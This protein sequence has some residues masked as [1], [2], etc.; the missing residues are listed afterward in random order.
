MKERAAILGAGSLGTIMGAIVSDRHKDVDLVLIDANKPHVDMLNKDGATVT[1]YM[2]MKNIPVKAITPDQMEG[3]YDIVIVLTK[4]TA[5]KAALTQL[6]PY[7]NDNSVVCTLQNGIPEESVAA[8]V[9]RER[10]VGGAVGWGAGWLSPGVSQL[11]TKPEAMIIEIGNLDNTVNEKLQR[12]EQFI[13]LACEVKINLNLMGFRWAKLLMNASFSGMSA[14]LGCT[15]G[16][17]LDDDKAVACAVHVADELIKV[18]R[19]KGITIE[20]IVP[21]KDF[22]TMEFDTKAGREAAIAFARDVWSVHRPQKASMMQ[23]MEK[24][25]PCEIDYIN[26]IVCQGGKDMGLATPFNDMIVSIVKAFEAKQLPFPTMAN[27]E[28]FTVP[29]L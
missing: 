11:Y 14:A 22:Y 27:L 12:I 4:Q 15:F 29:A 28:K 6:L 5:N 13:K 8:I 16:D 19:K 10:T 3:I 18:A 24:G 25:L 26:G 17:I 9:G 20:E 1:G 2:D 7:I 21:G 23:D